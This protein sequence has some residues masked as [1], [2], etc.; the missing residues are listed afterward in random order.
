L[1]GAYDQSAQE[2]DEEKQDSLVAEA[3][4]WFKIPTEQQK[5][6]DGESINQAMMEHKFGLNHE[7]VREIS[8]GGN[9]FGLPACQRLAEIIS[10]K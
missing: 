8:L 9:S 7:L 1:L 3:D 2:E 4:K 5:Y 6:E 10:D